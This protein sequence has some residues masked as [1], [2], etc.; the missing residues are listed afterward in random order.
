MA[1]SSS[2][3]EAAPGWEPLVASLAAACECELPDADALAS[4][5]PSQ[6]EAILAR[7]AALGA[8]TLAW[9]QQALSLQ[10]TVEEACG[11]DGSS[12]PRDL[13]PAELLPSNALGSELAPLRLPLYSRVMR[14]QQ[15][16]GQRRMPRVCHLPRQPTCPAVRPPDLV[17]ASTRAQLAC[18]KYLAA[19]A[20]TG[21][22]A[23]SHAHARSGTYARGG[24]GSAGAAG[25]GFR[26]LYMDILTD[27][28]ADELDALRT[29]DESLD[30]RGLGVL[31][32]YISQI[33][34]R[35]A[36]MSRGPTAHREQ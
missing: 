14:A 21:D 24:D 27:G 26:R 4:L 11:G 12:A 1:S 8:S 28:A 10:H 5:P 17:P 30:A 32:D 31:I 13:D 16:R 36:D 23:A 33:L 34:I 18:G 15:A 3:D 9:L 19:L 20:H 22:D 2:L 29:A 7:H 25:A 6:L 35:P